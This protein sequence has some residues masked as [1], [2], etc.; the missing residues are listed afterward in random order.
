MMQDK[1]LLT[2]TI[3]Y[4]IFVIPFFIFFQT[5]L[6]F[7]LNVPCEDDYGILRNFYDI[8]INNSFKEQFAIFIIPSNEHPIII[9][10]IFFG[11]SIFGLKTIN[12]KSLMLIGN[13]IFLSTFIVFFKLV[14]QQKLSY[15]VLLPLPYILLSAYIYESGLWAICSF[16]YNAIFGL[17]CWAIFLIFAS[18]P[19]KKHFFLGL[20]LL[21]CVLLCNG[22]GIL[23]FVIT[24]LGLGYQKR[25]KELLVV[26]GVL[27]VLKFV[28]SSNSYYK[29]PN[30]ISTIFSSF[31][32]L[33]GGSIKTDS[34]NSFIKLVG[35][36]II[37]FI[38]VSSLRYLVLQKKD[39]FTLNILII[40]L[41]CIGSL[42]GIALFRDVTSST[43]PDRYRLYPQFLLICVYLLL[44][45]SFPERFKNI[46]IV[47]SIFSIFYFIHSY[48]V[49]YTSILNGYQ[50][51]LLSSV[52]MNQNGSTLNGS[53]YRNLFD[54]TIKIYQ[55]DKIYDFDKPIFDLKD[56][57]VSNDKLSSSIEEADFGFI[58]KAKGIENNKV[59]QE[60]GYYI[61]LENPS[62]QYYF[63][64]ILHTRSSFLKII[65]GSPLL[66]D[67]I[68]GFIVNA[69]IPAD[70]Y[71]VGLV[72]TID[73]RPKFFQTDL[74]IK[75]KQVGYKQ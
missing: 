1:K 46:T 35:I 50:K 60:K 41:F 47:A 18:K 14:K 3:F 71:K 38:G 31:S 48:F 2:K 5:F 6:S 30:S 4:I 34:F 74:T 62:H 65:S 9:S 11:I 10:K 57:E 28:F 13:L 49:D 22:N 53:F 33:V 25:W 15:W 58:L 20:F 43:F 54:E 75:T 66:S 19:T 17:F 51:R 72:S 37:V 8:S 55:K 40:A 44:I 52:N 69:E 68:L 24:I 61:A 70:T 42:L 67:D 21:S 32:I 23:A 27:L 12:F 16:Q 45:K 36:G 7:A 39:T 29:T 73:I 59:S 63:L 26:I 64:P 56:I